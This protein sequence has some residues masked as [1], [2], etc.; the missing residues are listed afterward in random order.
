MKD[1]N[2][3]GNSLNEYNDKNNCISSSSNNE[4]KKGF[5]LYP[6]DKP[7]AV[8]DFDDLNDSQFLIACVLKNKNGKI[9]LWK[10]KD[11]EIGKNK[12]IEFKNKVIQKFFKEFFKESEFKDKIE[13]INE[14]PM[15]ESDDFLNLLY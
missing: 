3:N 7:D 8:L 13:E 5:F 11:I 1:K 4:S 9:Y 6:N 2:N 15:E 14:V 12:E 10:G